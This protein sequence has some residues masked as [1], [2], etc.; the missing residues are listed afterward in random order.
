[1]L[2]RNKKVLELK[3]LKVAKSS[4]KVAK[5]LVKATQLK[6]KSG[7]RRLNESLVA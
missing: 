2:K 5:G 4:L 3:Q 7:T 1:M 6:A